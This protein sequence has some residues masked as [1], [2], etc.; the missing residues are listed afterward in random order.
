MNS[1]NE[2]ITHRL[3]RLRGKLVLLQISAGLWRT[4][5]V[6]ILLLLVVGLLEAVFHFSPQVRLILLAVCSGG[7]LLV[8]SVNVVYPL[9]RHFFKPAAPEELALIWGYSLPEIND[10]LLNALQVYRNR[11]RDRTS[12][13]LAELALQDIAAELEGRSFEGALDR[14]PL[15]KYRKTAGIFFAL[16]LLFSAVQPK[17]LTGAWSRL[18]QPN[19]DFRPPP[20]FRLELAEAPPFVIRNEPLALQ[21]VGDGDLPETVTFKVMEEGSDPLFLPAEFDS[22]GVAVC[23]LANP[24]RD[25]QVFAFHRQVFSDTARVE[26][27]S[28]PF[29][30]ELQVRWFPPAY[31]RLPS[32]ASIG[33]RG[34]VAALKGSRVKVSFQADRPLKSAELLIFSDADPSKPQKF[35]MV[36]QGD[37]AS[38]EFLLL[39]SGYYNLILEDEDGI[40]NA[41]PVDYSL[42]PILDEYPSVAIFYPPEDAEVN[43]SLL[44]PL[45]AGARD[46]Y[47]IAR[48]RLGRVLLKGGLE[49]STR[50]PEFNWEDLPFD[51][52]EDGTALV[53]MLL[54]LN[55][56]N[57]L[58]GDVVLYKIEVWDNDRITGP[59]RA[60]TPVQRLRFPTMEEIFARLEQSQWEQVEDVQETLDRSYQLKEE[61][62]KLSEN[63]KRNPDLSWEEKKNVEDLIKKQQ[64]MA[65]QAEEMAQKLDQMIEQM[66]KNAVL[67]PETM[68]K[69]RELQQLLSEV[70]TPELME[71]MQ[72][73]QEALQ[74]QDPEQLRRAVENFTLNQEEFQQKMEKTLNILKQL[75]ME[76]KLDELAKRAEQLLEKQEKINQALKDSSTLVSDRELAAQEKQLE[77][78]MEAFEQAFKEAQEMLEGSPNNPSEQMDTSKQL[79]DQEQFPAQMEDMSG[80]LQQGEKTSAQQKGDR[81]EDGLAQLSQMMKKAKESMIEAGKSELAEALKRIAHDLL[82][83]SYRQEDLMDRSSRLDRASPRFR[84]LAQEQ[85]VLKS[86]LEKTAEALFKLSQ[87]S[88][89][90]TPQIGAAINQAFRGMEQALQGYTARAPRSVSRQQQ[91]SM[92]GLN[93][94]VMQID[95]SLEQMQSSSS[96]TGFSEM[97]EQLSKMA[98]KQGEINQGTMA[99]L[100]GGSNPGGL[101]LQQQAA[102]SR[103]AAEQQ[104]LQQQFEQW[105]QANQEI[106]KMLGRLG[107]LSREMKEVVDDLK[108]RQVDQ[109][110]LKRQERILRR[111]L[112]A[113]KSVREREYRKMRLSKTAEGKYLRPSPGEPE[114]SLSPDEIRQ[115]MLQALREGYTRDY[116]QLIRQYFEALAREN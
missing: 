81:I 28:R 3:S 76:M 11:E 60:E 2:K 71:A 99:L 69:Y 4:A 13:A 56:M 5:A 39:K 9:L 51:A 86:H 8:L 36:L 78:E 63:L 54:D 74:Q 14:R 68:E 95:K 91:A 46:D 104:A 1:W 29:I 77:S 47:G 35:S 62:E 6:F 90:I 88:F 64:D 20:P 96:S 80:D 12:P 57:L 59:K 48:M 83:L 73:L 107:E 84:K 31:S 102:L 100:P 61:L 7:V 55:E 70:M 49:D 75:Q 38:A 116:Q 43:E 10:R 37:Q 32:G 42:W 92:G 98:G 113:Q 67:S 114:L 34:D 52:F 27:K 24:Q 110:T 25:F 58:P 23:S 94:A 79:L 89:F 40:R 30:R 17:A 108:N 82:S 105:S 109:R 18:L 22:V 53:D 45:K 21:V 33:D 72:K 66:E 106:G 87:K 101:S 115:N 85:Q 112:D 50:R 26:V 93:Q 97:M 16:L 15:R 111:L 19:V 103:L 44:I 41:E 65:K